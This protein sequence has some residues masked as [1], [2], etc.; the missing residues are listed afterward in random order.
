MASPPHQRTWQPDDQPSLFGPI[1][2]A[3]PDRRSLEH[4]LIW[5]VGHPA[6]ERA[7]YQAEWLS[8]HE[9]DVIV[10][11]ETS[12]NEGCKRLQHALYRRGY[13]VIASQPTGSEYGVVIASRC[14]TSESPF[15]D[16]L[17]YLPFRAAAAI[18][19]TG[20]TEVIGV[21]VPSRNAEPAKVERKRRFLGSLLQALASSHASGPR[22]VCGDMNVLSRAHVP[23]Y[24]FFDEWEYDFL[25]G[26]KAMGFV[27]SFL[28]SDP[29]R[30]DYSWVGRTGDGYR[31]DYC[32]VTPDMAATVESCTFDHS[33]R[34]VGLSD[35]SALHVRFRG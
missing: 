29:G 28:L 35:H 8:R 23:K 19:P 31:Y 21:Y 30:Q 11:T 3:E 13:N 4:L 12:L 20:G 25:D 18:F 9:P 15:H 10:L 33:A 1:R 7:A 5:N 32:F 24:P 16:A 2:D 26:L 34:R 22:I 6:P 14:P 17:P 27:D